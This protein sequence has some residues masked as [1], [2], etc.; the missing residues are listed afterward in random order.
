MLSIMATALA[1]VTHAYK[2][3]LD[4]FSTRTCDNDCRARIQRIAQPGLQSLVSTVAMAGGRSKRD[5]HGKVMERG[6]K[7]S[8]NQQ[9]CLR[10]FDT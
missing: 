8:N 7:A 3:D 10:Q 2:Q 5:S 9:L 4:M 6:E 1:G